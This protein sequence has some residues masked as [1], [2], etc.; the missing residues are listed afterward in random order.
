MSQMISQLLRF[1]AVVIVVGVTTILG[2]CA[3]STPYQPLQ[4]GVGYSE[5]RIESN[6]YRVA[7][8]GDSTTSRSTTENYLLY[9][10]AEL[11]LD[12][13]FDYFVLS[14][15]SVDRERRNAGV[16]VGIGGF[17]FGSSGGV[18]VGVGTSTQSGGRSSNMAEVVMF[19]GRKP[20]DN[21]IAFDAREVKE[22][23]AD[24]IERPARADRS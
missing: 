22:S 14:G 10:A 15:S 18:G 3:T 11:T 16:N 8:T 19:K 17:S 13:G 4:R 20:D 9:R 2:G 12:K 6:R 21:P 23:L 5:Q 24:E 7:F 1:R